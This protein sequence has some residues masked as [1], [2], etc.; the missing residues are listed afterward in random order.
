MQI[1]SLTKSACAV[2]NK[3]YVAPAKVPTVNEACKTWFEEKKVAESKHGGERKV[4]TLEYW[5]NHTFSHP[6]SHG[7]FEN[8]CHQYRAG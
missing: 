1:S 5:R 2:R 3:A 6:S 8:R 4:R 7:Q